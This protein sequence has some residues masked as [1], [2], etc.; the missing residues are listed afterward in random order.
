LAETAGFVLW[1]PI[2]TGFTTVDQIDL[3][4]ADQI[5]FTRPT[6]SAPQ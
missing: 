6:K 2:K 1:S 3:T 5:G 4:K